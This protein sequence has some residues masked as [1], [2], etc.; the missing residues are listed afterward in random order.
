MTM[1]VKGKSAGTPVLP[2]EYG[3]IEGGF[4]FEPDDGFDISVVGEEDF[5][6]QPPDAV[7]L[8]SRSIM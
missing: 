4:Y 1:I 2:G 3:A 6:T 7:H 8:K 5:G